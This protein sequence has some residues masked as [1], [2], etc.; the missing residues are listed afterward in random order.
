MLSG[1]FWNPTYEIIVIS[2]GLD[3]IA[4]SIENKMTF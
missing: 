3:V 2:W 4:I 1:I